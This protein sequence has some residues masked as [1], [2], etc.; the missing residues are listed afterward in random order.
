MIRTKRMLAFVAAFTLALA[1]GLV[2]AAPASAAPPAFVVDT[3]VARI[4]SFTGDAKTPPTVTVR[5]VKQTGISTQLFSD[6]PAPLFCFWWNANGSGTPGAGT[7]YDFNVTLG[8]ATVVCVTVGDP[9]R[10]NAS[11]Y[12]NRKVNTSSI[13]YG[14]GSGSCNPFFQLYLGPNYYLDN[15][16]FGGTPLNDNTWNLE[17]RWA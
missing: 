11:S 16:N 10:H 13:V 5:E 6:C 15:R 3:A 14:S 7:R 4:V 1:G 8:S 2:V 9:V 12:A 17:V